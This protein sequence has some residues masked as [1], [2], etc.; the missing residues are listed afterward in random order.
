MVNTIFLIG[1]SCV[2]KTFLGLQ[3]QEQFGFKLIP[4]SEII[5]T[6]GGNLIPSYPIYQILKQKLRSLASKDV[7]VIDFSPQTMEY[8][9]QWGI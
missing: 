6:N 4:M 9:L 5:A 7:V 8:V 3:L 1:A 2:G